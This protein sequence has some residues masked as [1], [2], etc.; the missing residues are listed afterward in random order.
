[1]AEYERDSARAQLQL[2]SLITRPTLDSNNISTSTLMMSST[3]P[4]S[5]SSRPET[6]PTIPDLS[7]IFPTRS[8][9]STTRLRH[10]FQG[11]T[12]LTEPHLATPSQLSVVPTASG[13]AIHRN[14]C[15]SEERRYHALFEVIETEKSYLNSLRV[16]INVRTETELFLEPYQD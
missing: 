2:A 7:T 11:E 4:F 1:M 15:R 13:S 8:T 16:L 9:S 10:T 6:T 5:S 3:C 12:P 14:Y